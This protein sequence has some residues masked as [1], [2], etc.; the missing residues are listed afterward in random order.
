[1]LQLLYT[2]IF[3]RTGLRSGRHKKFL[4]CWKRDKLR[5]LPAKTGI[6]SQELTAKS[7]DIQLARDM[8]CQILKGFRVNFAFC[9]EHAYFKRSTSVYN[10][11]EKNLLGFYNQNMTWN[12]FHVFYIL[13]HARPIWNKLYPHIFLFLGVFWWAGVKA[14]NEMTAHNLRNITVLYIYWLLLFQLENSEACHWFHFT[15]THFSI[16]LTWNIIASAITSPSRS[17]NDFPSTC[18][19]SEGLWL[20][21]SIII[22]SLLI[23]TTDH[24]FATN[25]SPR[26]HR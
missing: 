21:E 18:P 25:P 8:W 12:A 5:Y 19:N 13:L 11:S 26:A 20:P 6:I 14:S 17:H 1:M 7:S 24:V 10:E 2:G 16:R 23:F 3:A 15:P 4:I 22:A 9:F